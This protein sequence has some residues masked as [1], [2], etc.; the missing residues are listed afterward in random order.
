LNT[1]T[2]TASGNLEYKV[3][4]RQAGPDI[5]RVSLGLQDNPDGT[6]ALMDFTSAELGAQSNGPLDSLVTADGVPEARI[7]ITPELGVWQVRQSAYYPFDSYSFDLDIL[8]CANDNIS[9]YAKCSIGTKELAISV[10]DPF[11]TVA[12]AAP[13]GN[14]HGIRYVLQRPF[15][16]RWVSGW[17]VAFLALFLI[18]LVRLSDPKD[19]LI[20]SAGYFGT[21]WAFRQLI[22]PSAIPIFP[23]II[24]YS[25]LFLFG[26][27]F[28]VVTYRAML[29]QLEVSDE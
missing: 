18:Y 24:D 6:Q 4:A 10:S 7:S 19:L 25:I 11:F 1:A 8:G 12:Q 14:G 20:K 21:M 29:G 22:V 3:S 13:A 16:V 27:L 5:D 23:T 28:I 2:H 9:A 17:V 26:I 15:F